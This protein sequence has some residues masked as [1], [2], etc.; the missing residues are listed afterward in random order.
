MRRDQVAFD[1]G[2]SGREDVLTSTQWI[3]DDG[4]WILVNFVEGVVFAKDI[5]PSDL[6]LWERLKRRVERR[7]RALWP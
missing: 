1:S 5:A 2:L 3:N 6:T 4:D 7:I